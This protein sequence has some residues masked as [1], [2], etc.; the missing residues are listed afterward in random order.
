MNAETVV[1]PSNFN[2]FDPESIRSVINDLELLTW[3]VEQAQNLLPW[4]LV[5]RRSRPE[6]RKP[7]ELRANAQAITAHASTGIPAVTARA[8]NSIP[9]W[10]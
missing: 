5:F 1:K 9:A 4:I 3:L 6:R 7:Q 10:L 8:S 2:F